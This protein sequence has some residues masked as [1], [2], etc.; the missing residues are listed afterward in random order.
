[1]PSPLLV[2]G[3]QT[4]SLLRPFALLAESIARPPLV[5]MRARNPWHLARFRLFGWYVRFII[6]HS[7]SASLKDGVCKYMGLGVSLSNAQGKIYPEKRLLFFLY[8][9]KFFPQHVEIVENLGDTPYTL[10]K[11]HF[12]R[13]FSLLDK[14]AKWFNVAVP[15][16]C[17][18][19]NS[20]VYQQIQG[21]P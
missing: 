21:D 1:V 16:I 10:W 3:I 12:N 7:F 9:L 11:T 6:L 13:D 19:E 8:F 17:L 14:C 5:A 18:S 2:G 15:D 20:P 4:Q